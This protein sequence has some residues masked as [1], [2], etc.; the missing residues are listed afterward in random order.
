MC[1]NNYIHL[2][3]PGW[4]Q[5]PSWRNCSWLSPHLWQWIHVAWGHPSHHHH[6][7]HCLH[8]HT[9]IYLNNCVAT[10]LSFFKTLSSCLAK[11]LSPQFRCA[12]VGNIWNKVWGL[13]LY[14]VAGV[15]INSDG[16]LEVAMSNWHDR[17]HIHEYDNVSRPASLETE[18]S[19]SGDDITSA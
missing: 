15:L 12:F 2:I 7:H 17:D 16:F 10:A 4:R 14:G 3:G 6:C 13:E 9:S 19:H 11:S 8:Q 5:L 18:T 1:I